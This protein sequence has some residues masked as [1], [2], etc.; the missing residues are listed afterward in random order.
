M[1]T[2]HRSN[3]LRFVIFTNDHTPAH[4]HAMSADGEAKIELGIV[5]TA[6]LLV[7]VRGRMSPRQV[8]AALAEGVRGRQR[9]HEQWLAIHEEKYP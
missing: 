1:P 7:W 4:V 6:P 3:G 8:R 5:G 9:M 2:V